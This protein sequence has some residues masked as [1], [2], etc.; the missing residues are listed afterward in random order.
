MSEPSEEALKRAVGVLHDFWF[1]RVD[2]PLMRDVATALQELMDERDA[3]AKDR[4]LEKAE[5]DRTWL[6]AKALQERAGKAEADLAELV[7]LVRRVR[8]WAGSVH[9]EH[10]GWKVLYAI[11]AE[12]EAKP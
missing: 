11:L 5:R 3:V 12:F 10:V 1:A 8:E 6:R 7:R 4:D 2:T 9:L